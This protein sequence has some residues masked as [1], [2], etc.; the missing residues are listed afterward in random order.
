MFVK[1]KNYDEVVK[2]LTNLKKLR[3]D[4]D[5]KYDKLLDKYNAQE[6]KLDDERAIA[7]KTMELEFQSKMRERVDELRDKHRHELDKVKDEAQRKLNAGIEENFT[8][9][10]DSLAKLHEE[11]NA[12]TKYLEKMSISIMENFAKSQRTALGYNIEDEE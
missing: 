7:F 5:R 4:Q 8:K 6:K 3:A 2:E 12:N 1:R 9:L 10:K 11:G